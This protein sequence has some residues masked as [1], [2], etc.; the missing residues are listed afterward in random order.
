[1][2]KITKKTRKKKINLINKKKLNER[3][4]VSQIDRTRDLKDKPKLFACANENLKK[5]VKVEKYL[6]K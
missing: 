2:T 3:N 4:K 6:I 5:K 1:M